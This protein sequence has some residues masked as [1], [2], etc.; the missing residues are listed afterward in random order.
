EVVKRGLIERIVQEDEVSK[1]TQLVEESIKRIT[2]QQRNVAYGKK[3]VQKAL[4]YGAVEDLLVT[5][6]LFKEN[7][8]EFEKVFGQA[9]K[10]Q[11]TIHIIDEDLDAGR[12]L[13]GLT[14]IIALLRFNID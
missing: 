12:K 11:A 3:E 8:D 4:D 7:R 14:G 9:E 2:K 13:K 5:D 10:Q 1:Q 6:S